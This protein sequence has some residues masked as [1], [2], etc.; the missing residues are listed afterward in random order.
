MLNISVN[1]NA[2]LIEEHS[3]LQQLISVAGFSEQIIAVAVNGEFVPKTQY[4]N[5]ILSADDQIDIVKPIGG[6]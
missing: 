6:G 5:T 3:N 2:L 1:N 4:S